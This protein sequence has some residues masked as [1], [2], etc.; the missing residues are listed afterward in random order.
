MFWRFTRLVYSTVTR[1]TRL[2]NGTISVSFD[3]R[4][5]SSN[6]IDLREGFGLANFLFTFP[7]YKFIDNR[8]RRFLLLISFVGMTLSL[9][10]VSGVFYITDQKIRMGLVTFFSIIIFT[11]FYSIG[12]G[13]IP[14]TLSAEVFP[15]CV[16]GK[17][18]AITL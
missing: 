13:P 10:V 3:H 18:L 9:I 17:Y 15:L 2:S 1:I 8:G 11:F 12:A 7:A 4:P 5:N 16:R 6:L 14:F